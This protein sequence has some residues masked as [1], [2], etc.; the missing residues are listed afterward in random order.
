MHHKSL[1]LAALL[2]ASL[3]FLVAAEPIAVGLDVSLEGSSGLAGDV[4]KHQAFHGLALLHADFAKLEKPTEAVRLSGYASL[5]A[6]A[7]KGPT[8]R[9]VGDALALS[10]TE[11]FN[12]VRLYSFWV[13][14]GN[15]QWSLR[16]GSLLA[17]EEFSGTAVGGNFFNSAFG[18]PTFI[19]ANTVNTGPAFFAAAPGARLAVKLG[20]KA[21]W[22][23]GIYDGDT[24]N[25]PAGDPSRNRDGLH[26]SVGGAQGW[27]GITEVAYEATAATRLKAG[28]WWHTAEFAD[29]R[30]DAAGRRFAQSGKAPATH[31]SNHGGYAVLEQTLAGESGKAGNIEAHARVGV[32]PVNRNAISWALDTGLAFT[33]LIPG[34]GDDVAAVGFT[35]AQVSP[36]FARTAQLLAPRDPAPDYERVFEVNYKFK[37]SDKVN[38]QPDLQYISHVGGSAARSNALVFLLRVNSTF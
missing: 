14:A 6:L 10:N 8:E 2:A 28:L 4:P 35:H 7:G 24:F 23:T 18:W 36:R 20:D 9:F 1:R 22:R 21:T 3:N 37:V 38:V 13:E 32:A 25:S 33:G 12:S 26:L 27:F 31:S 15:A 19:S 34:R 29:V 11:G 16:V 5:L 17:D 30:D